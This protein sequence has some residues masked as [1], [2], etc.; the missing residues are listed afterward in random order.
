M[1][2]KE[3]MPA[4]KKN[5]NLALLWAVIIAAGTASFA[6]RIDH[7]PL[8]YDESYS[9][10]IINQSFPDICSI[11]G[12]DSHPPLYYLALKLFSYVSGM[13]IAGLRIFSLLGGV[14]LAL[15]GTGPVRRIFGA[16][17]GVVFTVLAF[18]LPINLAMAQEMR[19][20]TWTAFLVA[21]CGLYGWLGINGNRKA[22]WIKFGICTAAAAY[23]HYFGLLA[24]VV[25][26]LSL[27]AWLLARKRDALFPYLIT[28]GASVVSYIPWMA[29]LF[30]QFA[31][32]SADFWIPPFSP[33]M[34][35]GILLYPFT[36]KFGYPI[37]LMTFAGL[38]LTILSMATGFFLAIRN[39]KKEGAAAAFGLWVYVAT[40]AV[41]IAASLFIRPML[42]LRYTVPLLGLFL[43][44]VAFG[45]AGF[46]LRVIPVLATL[47]FI[48]LFVPQHIQTYS[49]IFNGGTD[50]AYA[51]LK[52]RV[53]KGDVFVH[54]NE[55]TPG[56]FSCYF[57]DNPHYLYLAPDLKIYS[58]YRAFAPR[59]TVVN[60][61]EEIGKDGQSVWFIEWQSRGLGASLALSETLKRNVFEVVDNLDA[62]FGNPY[63]WFVVR[64]MK[65]AREK[66]EAGK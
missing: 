2:V 19:M 53:G 3:L 16:R 32:L 63:S 55:H 14:C 31:K 48:G 47:A 8:W 5:R 43:V 6:L 36:Q 27:F 41:A 57:P 61:L 15:L 44:P 46:K 33:D 12:H 58:N 39:R 29:F 13:S 1:T 49:L 11:T 40:I 62:T 34:I 7:E 20:Y 50:K 64:C 35:L 37:D 56:I 24:A 51:F 59:V 38:A 22:D 66:P 54:A 21:A 26:H 25:I 45:I 42:V 60:N 4:L 17:T 9:A 10:S 23:T 52:D 65:V 18:V 28:A 30:T